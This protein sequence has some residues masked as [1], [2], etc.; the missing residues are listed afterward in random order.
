MAEASN[1]LTEPAY[2]Q[3]FKVSRAKEVIAAILKT[4]L[5]GAAYHADNTSSWAREIADEVKKRL[6]EEGWTRYKYAVQVFIGEQ[7]GEGVRLG[8]RGF[9]DPKT[10][11]FA[12][13]IFQN[14]SLFCVATAFGVYLY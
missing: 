10:D 11:N 12:T 5:T 1:F 9:W 6:K 14:E 3:K 8:C 4:R 7:R 2:S 13:E